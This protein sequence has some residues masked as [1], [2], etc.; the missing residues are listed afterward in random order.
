MLKRINRVSP[1]Q[2]GKISAVIYGF[3]SILI[4]PFIIFSIVVS[5][6]TG[7]GMFL[8]VLIPICYVFMGFIM[9]IIT[10]GIYNVAA[11]W[12]G[13]IEV[14]LED[15]TAVGNSEEKNTLP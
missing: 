14:E 10:A 5:K 2:L 6:K 13:G 3:L 7:F 9:A 12:V 8:I 4:L 15:S 1:L 11:K